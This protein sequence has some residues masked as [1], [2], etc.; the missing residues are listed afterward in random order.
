MKNEKFEQFHSSVENTDVF[1][2]N[3]ISKYKIYTNGSG[4]KNMST[5]QPI[6]FP[7]KPQEN[8]V[9]RKNQLIYKI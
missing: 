5:F 2:T 3:G 8:P 4:L 9:S 1:L 7:M 6:H